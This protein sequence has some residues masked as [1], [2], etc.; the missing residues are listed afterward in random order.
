MDGHCK[1]NNFAR[2]Q[3][4]ELPSFLLSP[5]NVHDVFGRWW[6]VLHA[7]YRIGHT[8]LKRLR[9]SVCAQHL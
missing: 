4:V 9:H 2:Q 3:T 6:T 1:K 7:K 8:I 5:G